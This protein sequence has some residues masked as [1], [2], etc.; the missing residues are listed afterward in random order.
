MGSPFRLPGPLQHGHATADTG[1]WPAAATHDSREVAQVERSSRPAG[2]RPSA[3]EGRAPP[4]IQRTRGRSHADSN[5]IELAQRYRTMK[6][7]CPANKQRSGAAPQQAVA[8]RGTGTAAHAMQAPPAHSLI[9]KNHQSK[10]ATNRRC[11]HAGSRVGS[12][13]AT[14]Q[15]CWCGCMPTPG[16]PLKQRLWGLLSR[17]ARD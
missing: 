5:P 3:G 15:H 9:T 13:A 12:S 4:N 6:P 17:S 16:N 8:G 7:P 2:P 10:A 1:A 14:G 11:Y